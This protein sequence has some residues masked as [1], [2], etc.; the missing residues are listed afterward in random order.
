ME[1][2]STVINLLQKGVLIGGGIWT[3]WGVVTLGTA[4]K[5][6]NGPGMQTGIWQIVGGG[7]IVAAAALFGTLVTPELAPTSAVYTIASAL[8]SC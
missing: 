6:H 2:L 5:D 7:L 1:V 3:V 8:R 4:L